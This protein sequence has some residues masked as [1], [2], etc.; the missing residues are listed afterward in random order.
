MTDRLIRITTAVAAVISYRH[1]YELVCTHGET[2][3]TADWPRSLWMG[4]SRNTSL[5]GCLGPRVHSDG[6]AKESARSGRMPGRGPYVSPRASPSPETAFEQ[7]T[8]QPRP[9]G[10]RLSLF[11]PVSPRTSEPGGLRRNFRLTLTA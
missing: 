5:R 9:S 11:R 1:G 4:S 8:S 3:L 10:G 7:V 2:G 6:P